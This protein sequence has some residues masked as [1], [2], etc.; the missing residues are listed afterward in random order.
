MGD[1]NLVKFPIF[2]KNGLTKIFKRFHKLTLKANPTDIQKFLPPSRNHK[3]SIMNCANKKKCN[4][5]VLDM[6]R[7]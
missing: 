2:R 7:L 4:K 5:F 1:I 3:P 6:T